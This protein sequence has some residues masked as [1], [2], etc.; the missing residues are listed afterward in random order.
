MS[1]RALLPLPV[2]VA[3]PITCPGEGCGRRYL[4]W[5][6]VGSWGDFERA[7]EVAVQEGRTFID[8]RSS[9]FTYCGC[10]EPLDFTE[11]STGLLM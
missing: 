7:K 3:M 8:L 4:V 2:T 11:G 5:T 1:R 9:P 6:G 10:G